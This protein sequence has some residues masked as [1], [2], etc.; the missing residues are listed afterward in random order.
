MVRVLYSVL[1]LVFIDAKYHEY[2]V[3]KISIIIVE[4]SI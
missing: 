3:N 4:I 2:F 1:F